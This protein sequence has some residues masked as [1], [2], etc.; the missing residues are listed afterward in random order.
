VLSKAALAPCAKLT[1]ASAWDNVLLEHQL[2]LELRH[3][4]DVRAIF[5]IFVGERRHDSDLGDLHGDFFKGGGTSA[6][7]GD[8]T[9]EAVEGKVVEHLERMGK[10]APQLPASA[11]TIKATLAAIT[12]NQ[13]VKLSGVRADAI[14][15][16]VAAIVK[17][18]AGDTAQ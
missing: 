16:V 17:L 12:S 10:G 18:A 13:G 14:D 7:Q 15:K 8:V 3:R 11:R 4:G 6:C 2:A 1:A 5:P 9:V